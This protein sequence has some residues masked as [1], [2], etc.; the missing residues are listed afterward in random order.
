MSLNPRAAAEATCYIS[1]F[2][3]YA[4]WYLLTLVSFACKRWPFFLAHGAL[5]TKL[6]QLGPGQQCR[7]WTALLWLSPHPRKW[8]SKPGAHRGR[9]LQEWDACVQGAT[10]RGGAGTDRSCCI[11]SPQRASVF[12]PVSGIQWRGV[13]FPP[14]HTQPAAGCSSWP[15]PMRGHT[16]TSQFGSHPIL[17][18]C[19]PSCSL[20]H[21]PGRVPP[22][23]LLLSPTSLRYWSA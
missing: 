13:I 7:R 11:I 3:I 22:L 1:C 8:E 15:V 16:P 2:L 23:L 5:R 20:S 10:G 12:P 17:S 21:R 14:E 4:G 19:A 18:L 6:E 9:A